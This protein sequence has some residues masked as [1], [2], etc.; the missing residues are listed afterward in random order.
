MVLWRPI[1]RSITSDDGARAFFEK[2]PA[3]GGAEWLRDLRE[4]TFV[5]IRTDRYVAAG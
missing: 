4:R 3:V 1:A 2:E 5:E